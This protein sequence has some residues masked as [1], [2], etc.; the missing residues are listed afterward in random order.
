MQAISS[1][2]AHLEYVFWRI[3]RYGFL[4]LFVTYARKLWLI[5]YLFGTFVGLLDLIHKLPIYN[6]PPLIAK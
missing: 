5:F 6:S 3:I 2:F 1:K 4:Y